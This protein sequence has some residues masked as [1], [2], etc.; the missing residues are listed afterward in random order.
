MATQ[1]HTG[2]ADFLANYD[3]GRFERPS[4]AVDVVLLAVRAESLA[5]VAVRR[6]EHPFKDRWALPGGF[7]RMEE[8]LDAAAARVLREKAGLT[9]IFLEQLYTFGAPERDP[10][11]RVVSIA[12]Y[13]LV[14]AHRFAG[15]EKRDVTVG[16]IDV[17]PRDAED[18]QVRLVHGG[19]TLPIAFDHDRILTTAIKRIRGKVNYTPIAFAL[20]PPSFTLYDIQRV[21]QT[22]LNK[23]LNKDSFRKTILGSGWIEP[24]GKMQA[25]V[26]HRPA[27]LYRL[28][29]DVRSE[30]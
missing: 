14:D 19:K 5:T 3:P 18:A 13:A 24:T 11:T 2:E 29:P 6:D 23:T 17:A 1:K 10:R 20:L 15:V 22:V 25:Q 12:Y 28:R 9:D 26:G 16:Q 30:L 8:S 21:Y 4:V 27:R 7:V